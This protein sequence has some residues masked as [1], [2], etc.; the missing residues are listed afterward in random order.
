MPL[1]TLPL[2]TAEAATFAASENFSFMLDLIKSGR[3]TDPWI[4][5]GVFV[6]F[7]VVVIWAKALDIVKIDATAIAPKTMANVFQ[8]L[9][10]F[11]LLVISDVVIIVN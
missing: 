10:L 8:F 4:C 5:G 3:F 6:V 9:S 1:I 2:L 7:G 11:R